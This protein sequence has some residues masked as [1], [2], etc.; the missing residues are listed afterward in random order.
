MIVVDLTIYSL[1]LQ[2]F[3]WFCGLGR[4][5]AP[6]CPLLSR[7]P[8]F[9]ETSARRPSSTFSS[10]IKDA[11]NSER[12]GKHEATP[13]TEKACFYGVCRKV[14]FLTE[15]PLAALREGMIDS[16]RL[17]NLL[18]DAAGFPLVLWSGE[19]GGAPLVHF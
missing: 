18:A 5:G 6:I 10:I 11:R 7:T 2:V 16:S 15:G 8:L 12:Y 17:D 9:L 3:H 14:V 1:A 19:R 4:G 13:F